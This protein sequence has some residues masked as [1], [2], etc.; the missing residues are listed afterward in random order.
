[1]A[2]SIYVYKRDTQRFGTPAEKTSKTLVSC[3]KINILFVGKH[4]SKV[5]QLESPGDQYQLSPCILEIIYIQDL[6]CPN[7]YMYYERDNV[8]NDVNYTEKVRG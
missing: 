8:Q 4:I 3:P 5:L 2:G 6:A 7:T 1:M